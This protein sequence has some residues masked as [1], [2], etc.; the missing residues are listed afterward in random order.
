M[1]DPLA[2]RG[3]KGTSRAGGGLRDAGVDAAVA[4]LLVELAFD[5]ARFRFSTLARIDVM[6]ATSISGSSRSLELSAANPARVLGPR[7]TSGGETRSFSV[8]LSM[9]GR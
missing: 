8:S 5:L 1:G 7:T 9:A 4:A 2:S 3:G 6:L